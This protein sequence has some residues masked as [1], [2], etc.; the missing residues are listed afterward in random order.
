VLKAFFRFRVGSRMGF[1]AGALLFIIGVG[2]YLTMRKRR[3]ERDGGDP[4]T[5]PT[6]VTR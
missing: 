5:P 6:N 3:D 4:Y 1:T 2:E